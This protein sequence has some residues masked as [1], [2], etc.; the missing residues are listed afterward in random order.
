MEKNIFRGNA[1]EI[2]KQYGAKFAEKIRSNLSI[3]IWREG[4]EPL[5]LKDPDFIKW[6]DDQEKVIS[7]NWPWLIEEMH[8]VA[9][10]S[11]F[12]YR[13]ILLLNLRSWQYNHCSGKA[14]AQVEACSS[15]IITLADG[16]TANVGALDD[17]IQY[18]CGMVKIIPD[19]GY[20]FMT[21]PIT[22]TSWGNR[23]I[24]SAGLCVGESSQGLNGLK[25]LP[26][27]ICGDI[28][29]RV[30]L[31]TCATVSEV[32]EF[33]KQHPF[34]LNLAC[35]DKNG[36][37]FSAHQ[38]TAGLFEL[39]DNSPIAVT[40]HVICD[41]IISDMVMYWLEDA[42]TC[43]FMESPTTRLRRGRL[44]DFILKRD[45][46]CSAVEVRAYVADRM[47][48][49]PSSICPKGNVV[50][51]YANSQVE[52]GIM[53]IAEPAVSGNEKWEACYLTI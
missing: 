44:M 48:G 28:A 40:N 23:G 46:K 6:V 30:I 12:N 22:G 15:L 45:R 14:A 16:T 25:R 13:D 20:S 33:C 24:N 49:A 35:S 4:Y 3:L 31:Q 41:H 5:P 18:Y 50:L 37:V 21:F 11:G 19:H 10:G 32:R 1:F 7:T 42:G 8:A 52:P 26:G 27:S 36:D 34:T 51:T 47:N 2:G 29:L 43:A 9:E 17:G 53:W 38:T 39:T